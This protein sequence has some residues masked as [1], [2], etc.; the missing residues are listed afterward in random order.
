MALALLSVWDHCGLCLHRRHNERTINEQQQQNA[1]Q[2]MQ[3]KEKSSE[4]KGRITEQQ[5]TLFVQ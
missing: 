2:R 4:E 3:K 1:N 5:T